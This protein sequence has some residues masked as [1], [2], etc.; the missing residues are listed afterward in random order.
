MIGVNPIRSGYNAVAD[1]W[2][3]ITPGTDGLFILSL[4]HELLK[5]G[6]IDLDYLTR[7]T[8][9]PV[10]VD[11]DPKSPE[12]GLFLRDEDGKPL[13]M[14]RA[15]G[16]P[17]PFDQN[18]VKPDLARHH[19]SGITHRPVFPLMA[20]RYLRQTMRP[21]RGRTLRYHAERI[22]ASPPNWRASPL[23]KPSRSIR[24]GPISAAKPTRP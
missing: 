11:S 14:D 22:R 20:E 13:V 5:A 6:K 1:E 24:N 7:F 4:V 23:K 12:F 18:G 9:A 19:R 8:N 10:L 2:V 17:A 15:T 3:G 16:K 21:T